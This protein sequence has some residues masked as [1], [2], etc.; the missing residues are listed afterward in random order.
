MRIPDHLT[1]LLRT[2]YAGQ[3]ATVRTVHGTTDWFQIR[4]VCHPLLL[5]PSVFPSIKVFSNES[6]LRIRWP[7]YWSFHCS[8]SPS[9]EYSELISFR[10]DWLDLLAVQETLKRLLQHRGSKASV[11]QCSVFFVVQFSHPYMTTGK[12]T[13]A[14]TSMFSWQN[15]RVGLYW[16]MPTLH[17][18]FPFTHMVTWCSKEQCIKRNL[19]H[20]MGATGKDSLFFLRWCNVL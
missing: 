15:G 13:F 17:I 7:K 8:I 2:L 9:N 11:L 16:C 20:L 10:F 19:M 6:V 14:M 5:P 1:C 12:T 3:E 18:S 4:K